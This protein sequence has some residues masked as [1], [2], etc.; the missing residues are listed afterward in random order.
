MSLRTR[1]G[2]SGIL[3]PH[4]A[5]AI[6]ITRKVRQLKSRKWRTETVYAVTDLTALQANGQQ[7]GS[8]LQGH[9]CIE[10][11]LHWVRDVTFGEDL[12]QARTGSGP[13]V[14]A[15]LRNLAIGLL[16]LTGATNIAQ[17]V[18]HHAKDTNRPLKL[19]LTS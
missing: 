18:R 11:R 5:Q 4:A 6:Q 1:R 8:W 16:R 19:L 12:S 2:D 13:E 17:A 10:N 15:T 3:F 14:M 9:W 7:L